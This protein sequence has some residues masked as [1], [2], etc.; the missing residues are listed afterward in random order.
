MYLINPSFLNLA[1][2]KLH[3]KTRNK[4]ELDLR[5]KTSIELIDIVFN[6][7]PEMKSLTVYE[8]QEMGY[9]TLGDK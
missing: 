4:K 1:K 7:Y 9:I 2:K 6:D 5:S 8:I 3:L